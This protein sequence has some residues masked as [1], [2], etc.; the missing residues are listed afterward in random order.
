MPVRQ[1]NQEINQI[2]RFK[3]SARAL[4]ANESETAFD[5][6]LRKVGKAQP[7]PATK[8]QKAIKRSRRPTQR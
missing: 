1:K 3:D 8:P 7:A 2:D 5:Q 4:G 6:V